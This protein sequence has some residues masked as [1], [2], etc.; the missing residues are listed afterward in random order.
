VFWR[1]GASLGVKFTDRPLVADID[2]PTRQ[3]SK[4]GSLR[5]RSA[6]GSRPGPKERMRSRCDVRYTI[7]IRGIAVIRC[8]VIRGT[9]LVRQRLYDRLVKHSHAEPRGQT[10]HAPEPSLHAG[11]LF[12]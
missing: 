10:D 7:A 1:K 5:F 2:R 6:P 3:T 11:Q 8:V 12:I 4:A 9:R